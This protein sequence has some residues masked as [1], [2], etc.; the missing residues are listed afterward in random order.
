MKIVHREQ[1]NWRHCVGDLRRLRIVVDL[2]IP[3]VSERKASHLIKKVLDG[4]TASSC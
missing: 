2:G 3:L 4:K 1:R